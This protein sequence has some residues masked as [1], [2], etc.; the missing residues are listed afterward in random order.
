VWFRSDRSGIRGERG[1]R[2]MHTAGA[3]RY[4]VG[5]TFLK[6]ASQDDHTSIVQHTHGRIPKRVRQRR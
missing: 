2:Q 3:W 4:S 1:I 6:G 5:A